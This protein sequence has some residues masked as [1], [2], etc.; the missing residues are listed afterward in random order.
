MLLGFALTEHCNLRCPHCIRD[1]VT[2]VR[3]LDAALVESVLDQA[4]ALYGSVTA[5]FTGG[6]PLLHP[7]F[8]RIVAACTARGIPYRF[9]SNGWHV[10]RLMPLFDRHPPEAARLSLSGATEQIH[11]AERGRGSFRRVLLAVALFTSR[12]IPAALSIVI[13]R[14][15]RHQLREAAD[16]AEGLGCVRLHVILPQ[17]VPGSVAR[18][19]DLPPEEWMAVRHETEAIAREP[20]RRTVVALDYGAPFDGPETACDT[21]A[22]RRIYVDTRGRVCTCCQLS[23]YGG[24]EAEVVADLHHES[25]ASAHRKYVERLRELRAAQAPRPGA[26]DVFDT[27]PC[28]RC[29]RATGKLEWLGAY[30]SSAWSGAAA[31]P[32]RKLALRQVAPALVVSLLGCSSPSGP[33]P[34]PAIVFDWSRGGVRSIYRARLDGSDTLRLTSVASDDEHPSERGGVVVFTSYRDG[35]AQLYA[36]PVAGGAAHRVT[37][38]TFNETQPALSPDGTRIAYVSDSSG[39]PKLWLCA[40]DGAGRQRLTT[41]FG[42]AGSAEASPSWG[43][44][45]DRL[46]FVSTAGGTAGLYVLVLGGLPAALV[47]DATADVEPAWSPDGKLV[48]FASTRAGGTKIF[49]VDVTSQQITPVTTDTNTAGQPAWLADGRLVYT[50]W[51]NGA[52]E[53]KW[54]E[55]ALVGSATLVGLPSGAP[56]HAAA[57]Y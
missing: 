33:A 45:S 5:S 40:S 39:V 22:V 51:I 3:S 19:S 20:G 21:F 42:F 18:D 6:E 12:R 50:A 31:R 28:I 32:A 57:V 30:P 41:G 48:A 14:R 25:L 49:T 44:A 53:L 27:L 1:D 54:L 52:P 10:K 11:D 24:N 17:P 13:D 43:P 2:T 35:H 34:A 9:V 36:V 7:E 55:P 15:D 47:S 56:Q 46:V 8:H 37:N 26:G 23:Q 4:L 29:A 16:L 38:T